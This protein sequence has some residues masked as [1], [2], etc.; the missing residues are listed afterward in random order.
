M[1]VNAQNLKPEL[2]VQ[3]GPSNGVRSVA[4]HKD[5]DLLA[6]GGFGEVKLWALSTKTELRTIKSPGLVSVTFDPEGNLLTID[7]GK[8]VKLWNVTSGQCLK[9]LKNSFELISYSFD[10]STSAFVQDDVINVQS[11]LN[12]ETILEI[13]EKISMPSIALS[14]NGSLLAFIQNNEIR[15][16]DL[17]FKQEIRRKRVFEE[18]M[19]SLAFSPDNKALAVGTADGVFLLDYTTDQKIRLPEYESLVYSIAFS[20]NGNYLVGG[21]YGMFQDD[22]IRIWQMKNGRKMSSLD[23]FVNAIT[24]FAFSPDSRT[25]AV[26]D[27]SYN[28]KIMD[29]GTGQIKVFK[30]EMRVV[31]L[32]FS[33]DGNILASAG[34]Q[35]SGKFWDIKTGKTIDYKNVPEWGSTMYYMQ[36]SWDSAMINDQRVSALLQKDGTVTLIKTVGDKDFEIATIIFGKNEDWL[37]ITPEGYFDGTPNAWKQ[38]IW[39]YNNNTFDYS[40]VETHFKDFFYPNLLGKVLAGESPKPKAGQ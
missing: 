29:T 13:K 3:T 31:T 2:I 7:T 15:I 1:I 22:F 5:G 20:P 37:V 24:A 6:T 17:K 38:L 26:S 32:K 14:A 28:I 25:L 30:D 9:I 35:G 4:I 33:P 21:V 23:N 34:H 40:S 27:K 10:G 16:W 12:Q 19:T 11:V 36:K 39:R 18:T 8:T